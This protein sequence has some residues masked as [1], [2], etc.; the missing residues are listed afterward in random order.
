M[1]CNRSNIL[2]AFVATCLFLIPVQLVAQ[3]G[4]SYYPSLNK[5]YVHNNI[6]GIAEA[7]NTEIYL[8]GKA[9]TE[10]YSRSIPYFGRYDKKG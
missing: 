4:I 6:V 3:T 7:V 5:S 8:I 9:S 2:I 10:D 1:N